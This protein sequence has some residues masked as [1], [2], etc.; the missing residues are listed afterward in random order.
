[1]VICWLSETGNGTRGARPTRSIESHTVVGSTFVRLLGRF[2]SPFHIDAIGQ[3]RR[4]FLSQQTG[5][6]AGALAAA[7]G[8]TTCRKEAPPSCRSSHSVTASSSRSTTDEVGCRPHRRS[9]PGVM[10]RRIAIGAVPCQ[11]HRV[12]WIPCRS[13]FEAACHV[14]PERPGFPIERLPVVFKGLGCQ[15][16]SPGRSG[17]ELVHSRHRLRGT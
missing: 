1:M 17:H 14:P 12:L 4:E 8:R 11:R 6:T 5:A 15:A 16:H 13:R 10:E 3:R 7:S 2:R 9:V